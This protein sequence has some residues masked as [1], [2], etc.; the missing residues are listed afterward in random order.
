M[1]HN[2]NYAANHL[3]NNIACISLP[4]YI[5][6][7]AH[8]PHDYETVL[9]KLGLTTLADMHISASREFLRKLLRMD[10]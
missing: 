3:H 7:I 4:W 9:I 10:L 5:F 8:P 1:N 6:H 2:F